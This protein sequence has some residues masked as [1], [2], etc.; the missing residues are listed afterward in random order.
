M[1]FS[2]DWSGLVGLYGA[3]ETLSQGIGHTLHPPHMTVTE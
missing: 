3:W 2:Q 1:R